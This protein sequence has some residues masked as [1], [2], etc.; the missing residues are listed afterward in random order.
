MSSIPSS[1]HGSDE[2]DPFRGQAAVSSSGEVNVRAPRASR[3]LPATSRRSRIRLTPTLPLAG[4][5]MVVLIATFA[6]FLTPYEPTRADLINSLQPPFWVE[7]G[8]T[9][10]MLGT[11]G[12]GRDIL[13]RLMYG[14]RVS[15]LVA[16]FSLMIA[17][18]IGTTVGVV[19]GYVGGTVDSLL[20]RLV[21]IVLAFPSIIV[22]LVLSVALGPSFQNLVLVLG[23]LTWPR[24]ARLIRGETL[25][26]K[27]S[28][29][30]RYSRA[31]G[32][33][34][35]AIARRH[36]F[37]NVLPTLLVATTLEIGSVILAEASLSFLGAGV[38][39][40]SASWGVMISEGRGLISSGWWIALFPGLAIS[41]TVLSSNALGDWLRDRFDPRTREL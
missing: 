16:V 8:S 36:V 10:H 39:P 26:L 32:V 4:L 38:P 15:L 31:I 40:P 18:S 37:P 34:W 12:F 14:A 29:F 11:D 13:T 3:V 35:T 33:P 6:P 19:A 5:A 22:A 17:V 25:L 24:I 30:V 23:L 28:E 7:G 21:D 9:A 27:G 2:A 1:T 20:M 41:A